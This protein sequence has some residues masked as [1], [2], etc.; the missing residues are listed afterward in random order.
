MQRIA[1]LLYTRGLVDEPEPRVWPNY[2]M[3]AEHLGFP[4]QHVRAMGTST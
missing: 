4:P 1:D 3:A 2:E